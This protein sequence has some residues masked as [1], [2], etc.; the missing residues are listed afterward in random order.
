MRQVIPKLCS[1]QHQQACVSH[2]FLGREF[3]RGLAGLLEDSSHMGCRQV[4]SFSWH[5][6]LSGGLLGALVSCLPSLLAPATVSELGDRITRNLQ[7]LLCLVW[8]SHTQRSQFLSY[9]V[10][11][12]QVTGFNSSGGHFSLPFEERIF[13]RINGN[14]LKPPHLQYFKLENP[15]FPSDLLSHCMWWTQGFWRILSSSVEPCSGSPYEI[16]RG[17]LS[18]AYWR[19]RTTGSH[20]CLMEVRIFSK[21]PLNLRLTRYYLEV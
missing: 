17:Q 16:Q 2:K 19:L 11:E 20:M 9:S 14:M 15:G 18:S 21:D 6:N 3:E 12:K 4:A 13:Q 1:L 8:K 10:H 7:Y 5:M